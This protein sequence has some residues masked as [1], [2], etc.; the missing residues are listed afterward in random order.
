LVEAVGRDY[1]AQ[2]QGVTFR[3][4]GIIAKRPAFRPGNPHRKGA[5]SAKSDFIAGARG[6]RGLQ[7]FQRQRFDP[8]RK[9]ALQFVKRH[10]RKSLIAPC[11]PCHELL[12]PVLSQRF[13]A[14]PAAP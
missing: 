8:I 3:R 4:S 11:Q 5:F 12:F 6:G 9:G 1:Q 10:G 2:R 7:Q 14:I 13:P